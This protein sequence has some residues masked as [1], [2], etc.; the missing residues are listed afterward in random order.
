M[1][2][3]PV[4][5]LLA[6]QS[7]NR[8]QTM[9]R[10]VRDQIESLQAQ[11]EMIAQ[12]LAEKGQPGTDAQNGTPKAQGRPS[13]KRDVFKKIIAS[14]PDH[15]WLPAEMRDAL[16]A[17]GIESNSPAIRVMLRRMGEA[18]EIERGPDG[19]GWKLK[20]ASANGSTQESL[21][22]ATSV[23]PGDVGGGEAP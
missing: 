14:R 12:A 17:E 3:D 22:E 19:T 21:T 10:Q 23:G 4:V 16:A 6:K 15:A 8:L 11:D 20:L 1:P 5:A 18:G 7:K 13:N 9:Q 2:V